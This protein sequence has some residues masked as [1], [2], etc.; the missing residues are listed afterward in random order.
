MNEHGHRVGV[1][2]GQVVRHKPA[3]VEVVLG[4]APG[5]LALVFELEIV[6]QQLRVLEPPE[7]PAHDQVIEGRGNQ[8]A[9][10]EPKIIIK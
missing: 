3:L 4:M 2:T 9:L 7:R 8:P 10:G 5:G 1:L 6:G